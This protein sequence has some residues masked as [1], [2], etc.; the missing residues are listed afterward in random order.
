[1]LSEKGQQASANCKG[2][3]APETDSV[4]ISPFQLTF[5]EDQ[6]SLQLSEIKVTTFWKLLN[7]FCGGKCYPPTNFS[8]A[9]WLQSLS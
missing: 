7:I 2:F 6:H 8:I 9:Y 3:S 5:A 1:M 4:S